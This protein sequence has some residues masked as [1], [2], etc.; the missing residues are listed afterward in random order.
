MKL[1]AFIHEQFLA[2]VDFLQF[3]FCM[4][5]N[6]LLVR[7]N[8]KIDKNEIIDADFFNDLYEEIW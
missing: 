4:K 8:K 1:K 2:V 3:V 5:K 6:W 7:C